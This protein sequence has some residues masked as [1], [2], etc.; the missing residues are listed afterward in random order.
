MQPTPVGSVGTLH[1]GDSVSFC[2]LATRPGSS[3]KGWGPRDVFLSDLLFFF[4]LGLM[5]HSLLNQIT[6]TN[7]CYR[8]LQFTN[9][10]SVSHLTLTVKPYT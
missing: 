8:T 7:N 4:H 6:V 3:F 1:R 5:L 2:N 9:L 10:Y